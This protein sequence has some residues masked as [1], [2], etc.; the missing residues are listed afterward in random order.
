MTSPIPSASTPARF[1]WPRTALTATALAV[2]LGLA[3]CSTPGAD[4]AA[5]G[6]SQTAASEEVLFFD[7][8]L[9]HDVSVHFS[10]A[11]YQA[12]LASYSDSGDKDWIS[13][14]VTIDGTTLDNVGLRLKRSEERRV[15]KECPV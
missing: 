6:S 14:S 3:A 13:A 11:D 9:V 15:G 1:P 8:A 7:D 12:M 5:A 4:S 10:D 2:A